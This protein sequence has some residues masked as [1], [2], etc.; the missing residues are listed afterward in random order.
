MKRIS[1]SDIK[2]FYKEVKKAKT[3][4]IAGHEFPDADVIGSALSIYIMIKKLFPKKVIDVYFKDKI[5]SYLNFLPEIEKIKV[6]HDKKVDRLYDLG[7]ILECSDISRMGGII[8]M[9]KLNR[10]IH[11]DHH[12]NHKNEH[13]DGIY[14]VYPEY[15]SCAEII[16]DIFEKLKLNKN[17]AL[18]IYVGILTDTGMFQWSNTNQHS[19]YVASKLL[20][21]G[22]KPYYI[23][24]KLFR[25][26]SYKSMLLLSKVLSTM[27]FVEINGY[28]VGMMEVTRNML[29]QT[30]TT[31]QDT[32]NFINFIMDVSN[33]N[34][35]IMFKEESSKNTKVSFRSDVVNVEKIC[36]HWLGG[37]HKS[38]AGALLNFKLK[39]AR[40]EVISYLRKVL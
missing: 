31:F 36:R 23:Y 30:D 25:N 37:G 29:K 2:N 28:I 21:Y 12:L 40:Q 26:K 33:T 6:L 16:F 32:E 10:I 4:F 9:S 3:I 8:D 35:G 39:E 17:I 13:K 34:I 15:A 38:A 1:K 14:I 11:I 24:K 7:I 20:S 5:P 19:F 22:I 18:C 27:K